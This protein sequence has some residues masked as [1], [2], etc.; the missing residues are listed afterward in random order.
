MT[1]RWLMCHKII[2]KQTKACINLAPHMGSLVKIEFSEL[3]TL[4]YSSI[5]F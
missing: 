4:L 1:K 2:P 3:I 5:N